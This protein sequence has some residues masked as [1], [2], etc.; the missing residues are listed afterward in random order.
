MLLCCYIHQQAVV[1][2]SIGMVWRGPGR[3]HA[4][5]DGCW[6]APG[7]EAV[8]AKWRSKM[9]RSFAQGLVG[10]EILLLNEELRFCCLQCGNA[11]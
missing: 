5:V 11:R 9:W 10:Y 2:E 3:L 7:M 8:G 1:E 4:F 6:K